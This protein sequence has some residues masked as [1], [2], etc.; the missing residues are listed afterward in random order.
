MERVLFHKFGFFL[1]N[2]MM[3][4][5]ANDQLFDIFVSNCRNN[6]SYNCYY[7]H[8]ITIIHSNLATKISIVEWTSTSKPTTG[9]HCRSRRCVIFAWKVHINVNAVWTVSG[10]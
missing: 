7:S 1:R 10:S 2:M 3:V 6:H 5:I 9:I 4:S 8:I